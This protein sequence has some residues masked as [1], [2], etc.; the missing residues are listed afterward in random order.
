MEEGNV[1]D[2]IGLQQPFASSY[3]PHYRAFV[4][5][6][7]KGRMERLHNLV[8]DGPGRNEINPLN[9]LMLR[10]LTAECLAI[11][12]NVKL[13]YESGIYDWDSYVIGVEIA[14]R[15][16][17]PRFHPLRSVQAGLPFDYI[18]VDLMEISTTSAEGY[19]FV[20]VCVDVATKFV[21]LRPLRTKSAKEVGEALAT[22]GLQR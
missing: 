9:L 1:F 5:F 12:H 14:F 11:E 15:W 4:S 16:R 6:G 18:A 20:M 21:I 22:L 8:G 19:N 3:R 2:N 13:V 7:F 10:T 17:F